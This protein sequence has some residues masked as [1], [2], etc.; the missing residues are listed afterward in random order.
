M[1]N[2]VTH[3]PSFP[4]ES[5]ATSELSSVH[6]VTDSAD[7]FQRVKEEISHLQD[8]FTDIVTDAQLE[9][10]DKESQDREFF[11]NFRFYLMFLPASKKTI[12]VKFFRESENDFIKAEN[13][14]KLFAILG[15]YCNYSNYEIVLQIIKKFCGDTLQKRMIDYHA[16]YTRFE[17]NTTVDVYVVAISASKELTLAFNRMSVKINKPTSKCTL[18]DLRKLREA[19]AEKSSLASHSVYIDTISPG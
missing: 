3:A 9:L 18:Y 5:V 6:S 13:I 7:P 2:I 19:L 15:R 1:L 8:I 16:S 10:S 4:V 11:T 12:H 14:L 17:M